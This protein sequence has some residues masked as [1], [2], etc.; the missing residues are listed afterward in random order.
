MITSAFN[1]I[2]SAGVLRKA[3]LGFNWRGMQAE[4]KYINSSGATLEVFKGSDFMKVRVTFDKN[5]GEGT[6]RGLTT[7]DI[8]R[9]EESLRR[10]GVTAQEMAMA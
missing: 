10:V 3:L 4:V 6:L 9:I 2:I 8:S 7:K 5:Y 1:P